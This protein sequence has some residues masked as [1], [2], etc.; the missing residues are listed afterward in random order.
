MISAPSHLQPSSGNNC[1]NEPA[2]TIYCMRLPVM[3]VK[4]I[5]IKPFFVGCLTFLLVL[6]LLV[7]ISGARQNSDLLLNPTTDYLNKGLNEYRNHNYSEAIKFF[8]QTDGSVAQLFLAKSYYGLGEMDKASIIADNLSIQPPLAIAQEARYVRALVHFQKKE[9][10]KALILLH[11][12]SYSASEPELAHSALEMKTSLI[13][14]L[15]FRQRNGILR[16]INDSELRDSLVLPFLSR[17]KRDEARQLLSELAR[18]NRSNDYSEYMRQIEQLDITLLELPDIL[19]RVPAG[20]VYRIG[21]MLPGFKDSESDLPVSRGLYGGVMIAADQY[22]RL[23]SDRKIQIVFIDTDDFADQTGSAYLSLV[24]EYRVDFV[25]GPL[26]SG[27]VSQIASL[28]NR[29][30][31][32][33]FAPL[34]NT[35][36]LAE[37]NRFVYQLNPSFQARGRQF[38][39]FIVENAE[40]KRIGVITERGSQ[41][42]V[43]AREF[44]AEAQALGAQVPLFFSEDF[45][46]LGYSVSHVLPWF[47]NDSTMIDT[48]LYRADSLDAVFLSF[49]GDAAEILLDL[50][51]TGLE[52]YRP[53]YLILSNE[54]MIYL[55]HDLDRIRRMNLIYADTYLLRESDEIVINLGYDYRNRIGT[56]PNMFSWIAYDLAGFLFQALDLIGNPDDFSRF[57]PLFEPWSGTAT[58]I[59]FGNHQMNQSLQFFRLTQAGTVEV[60]ADYLESI[61]PL[62]TE[63]QGIDEEDADFPPDNR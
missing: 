25:I 50:S 63:I 11:N 46:S 6:V 42:E 51:L 39:K 57:I 10:D 58:T 52:A 9:F 17:Y 40:R 29:R 4:R 14:Y 56:D 45:A 26:F 16:L 1:Y 55:D 41:G 5:N 28:S 12:L 7:D 62:I 13:H 47:A 35:I 34:A 22:N 53:D 37:D 15:S 8:L 18:L 59:H 60:D 19:G 33:T 2:I 48:L 21:V 61:K 44:R 43:E 23:N 30:Q 49:T 24:E 36:T 20:T 54:T 32:P 31:I 27:Q 38:A 3:S